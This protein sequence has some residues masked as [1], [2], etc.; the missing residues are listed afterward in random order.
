[1]SPLTA[2]RRITNVDRA[3]VCWGSNLCGQAAGTHCLTTVRRLLLI[4][5]VWTGLCV[6]WFLLDTES[7]LV[8]WSAPG[9]LFAVDWEVGL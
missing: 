9:G 7:Q 1:M 8:A 3:V 6:T 4:V 2:E 5:E